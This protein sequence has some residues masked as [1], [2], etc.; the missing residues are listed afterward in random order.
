MDKIT[1]LVEWIQVTK[2]PQHTLTKLALL[3]LKNRTKTCSRNGGQHSFTMLG[4]VVKLRLTYSADI[5]IK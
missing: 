5:E 3:K 2:Q 1:F 4:I